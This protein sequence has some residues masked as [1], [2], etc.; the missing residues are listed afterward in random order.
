MHSRFRI[1]LD[2]VLD[3]D[4]TATVIEF[5]R[6]NY[7]LEG[8]ETD[9]GTPTGEGTIPAPEF[10]AGIEHALM[11]LVER[12]PLLAEANVEVERVSCKSEEAASGAETTEAVAKLGS[13]RSGG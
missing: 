12:N 9:V 6:R 11:E 3:T 10:I 7:V 4:S 1:E 5:A 8:G 2:V 13:R